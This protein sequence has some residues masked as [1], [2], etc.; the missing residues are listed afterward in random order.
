MKDFIEHLFIANTHDTL[1]CFSSVG[2]V[3]WKKVYEF[4]QGGRAAR[5]KPIINLLPLDDGE[6]INAIL[7]R[8]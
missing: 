5:G 8:T 1:L 4:P 3:Y 7:G 6:H 2:K